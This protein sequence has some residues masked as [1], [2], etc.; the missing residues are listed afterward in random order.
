MLMKSTVILASSL[1]ATVAQADAVQDAARSVMVPVLM[2]T[3]LPGGGAMPAEMATA[4]SECVLQHGSTDEIA[5]LAEAA[6]T[7]PD[8]MTQLLIGQ[9]LQRP[10]TT[11]CASN[12]LGA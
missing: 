8:V 3:P 12:A 10:E 1:F 2:Q 9:I 11:L 4:I 5:M 7:G 6:T